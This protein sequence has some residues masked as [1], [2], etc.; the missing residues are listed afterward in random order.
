MVNLVD[1]LIEWILGSKIIRLGWGYKTRCSKKKRY[2]KQR[3]NRIK[4][5]LI[6]IVCTAA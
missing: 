1:F 5:D 6:D 2:Y 4:G 3:I